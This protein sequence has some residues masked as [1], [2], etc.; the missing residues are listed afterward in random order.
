[1]VIDLRDELPVP[2]FE[3]RLWAEL[4]V[5]HDRQEQLEADGAGVGPASRSSGPRRPGLRRPGSRRPGRRTAVV[6]IAS[7]A[8]AAVV[9]TAVVV[10]GVAHRHGHDIGQSSASSTEAPPV[11]I[12][13]RI[14]AATDAAVA[15][16]VV[17][18]F[19]DS[20][21]IPDAEGWSDEQSGVT[22][23]LL[24]DAAGERALDSG[25]ST[26]PTVDEKAPPFPDMRDGFS[27]DDPRIPHMTLRQVDYCFQRWADT[28]TWA[29][30]AHNVAGQIRDGLESGDLILDGTETVDGRELIR[31]INAEDLG[32]DLERQRRKVMDVEGRQVTITIPGESESI[33]AG[34]V[35]VYLVD[36]DTYRP[37]Q[38]TGYPG[39]DD[40]YVMHFEYLPRT[41]ENLALLT[42]PIPEGFVHVDHLAGDGERADAGCS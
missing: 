37:I 38:L 24:Y 31:V 41:P 18:V 4:A 2:H 10:S 20:T 15:N 9:V 17:H 32:Q 21:A 30:P 36:P 35:Y 3:D 5:L 22:R 40:Q 6:G 34:E 16:S 19:Q 14:I 1:M 33:A 12:E 11:S 7:L 29:L 27:P 42:P 13:S 25:R 39:S 26:P 28:D 8:A 23:N